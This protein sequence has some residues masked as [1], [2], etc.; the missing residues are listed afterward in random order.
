MSE[1]APTKSFGHALT[2]LQTGHAIRRQCWPD[3]CYYVMFSPNAIKFPTP[4][5]YR[6]GKQHETIAYVSHEMGISVNCQFDTRDI[7]SG[8]WEILDI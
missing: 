8:D 1:I 4:N 7:L 5:Q 6:L 3:G 2:Y